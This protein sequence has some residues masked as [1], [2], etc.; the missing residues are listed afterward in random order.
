MSITV[1][2]GNR[3]ALLVRSG[4]ASLRRHRQ[5]VND[6]NVFPVPDGDTGDNM[7]LTI[8]SGSANA[9]KCK[10]KP[11]CKTAD[12]VAHGMLLGARGNSGVILSRM[13]A[14]LAKGL[15]D[16]EEADVYMLADA[17]ESSIAEAYSAVS[18][19]VEGTILSVYRDA[20]HFANEQLNPN[21]TF[22]EY[23]DNLLTGSHRSL[24]RTPEL[25]DVLK[26]AGVVDS[27]GAGFELI[28]QGMRDGLSDDYQEEDSETSDGAGNAP[29][30]IDFS[31]FTEESELEFGYCTEFLLRL[32]RAKVD[33]ETFDVTIITDFLN[34]IGNSVVSFKDGSIVKAH[35]HTMNPGKVLNFCQQYGEFLTLKIENM[36]L[37]H[38]EIVAKKEEPKDDLQSVLKAK[39]HQRYGVVTV[40]AGEGLTKT[41]REL[42]ADVVIAGGQSMN[43][44]AEQFIEAFQQISADTIIVLP[45]NSNIILTAQQ[46]AALYAKTPVRIIRTKTIGEG[47]AALSMMDTNIENPDELCEAL[48]E[49]VSSVVTGLV[50][51]ATRSTVMS[52]IEMKVGDYIGF[53]DDTFYAAGKDRKEVVLKLA[54]GLDAGNFDIM[55][56]I[57]GKDAPEEE[58]R[59][60]LSALKQKYRLM[61]VIPV[62]GMQPVYDYILVLE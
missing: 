46:A 34:S 40:A 33:P 31:L 53:E 3:F 59:E 11:L 35:V 15:G 38:E 19:P 2:N 20:I 47:Y 37:Q 49:V 27:G 13:F 24:L 28:V 18:K 23:F 52:G 55:L 48:N 50:S 57:A 17:F 16:A 36:M 22:E 8:N 1:L 32:Q 9:E 56:V 62:I 41:F 5:D 61:D 51:T 60:V 44:S 21:T 30:M 54:E 29:K 45:N 25:L 43:P 7:F 26:Q 6:L 42:G 58:Q 4:A 14:G 10:D 39:K 12:E